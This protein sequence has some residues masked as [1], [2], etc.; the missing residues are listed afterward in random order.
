MKQT[1]KQNGVAPIAELRE[2]CVDLG[3]E[4]IACQ[5][6]VDL[7]GMNKNE[8]FDGVTEWAGAASY[9]DRASKADVTL[10]I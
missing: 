10:Y 8:F 3:V 1:L 4:I 7:F 5:M 6:T 9:L 2:A